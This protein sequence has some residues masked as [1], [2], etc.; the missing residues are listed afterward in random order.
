MNSAST[1]VPGPT[2]AAPVS[3]EVLAILL[4]RA[5][6]TDLA[7]WRVGAWAGLRG[8]ETISLA[9]GSVIAECDEDGLPALAG[10][11]AYG[12]PWR[13]PVDQ[14]TYSCLRPIQAA[15]DGGLLWPGLT[16][17]SLSIRLR[18]AT[19]RL[20][21]PRMKYADLRFRYAKCVLEASGSLV[22]TNRLLRRSAYLGV[23]AEVPW[24]E[25][26]STVNRL[27]KLGRRSQGQA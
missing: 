20:G 17:R 23:V 13:I 18:R 2:P 3:E 16:P 9:A 12:R 6:A 1:R 22:V 21:L 10:L 24:D 15:A 4:N 25:L 19:E 8:A 7:V 5:D 11:D 26:R 27:P 14:A